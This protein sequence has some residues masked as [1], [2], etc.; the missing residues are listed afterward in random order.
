MLCAVLGLC[1]CA[2]SWSNPQAAPEWT[3]GFWF[4]GGKP[5]SASLSDEPDVLFVHVGTISKEESRWSL[6]SSQNPWHVVGQWPDDLPAAKEYWLVYRYEKQAV[7][8]AVVA[9]LLADEVAR[10]L[11][12]ARTRRLAVRGVQLDIDSPSSRLLEYAAFL[13]G[14]R[15][16]LPKDCQLSITALLDWF[17]NGTAIEKVIQV[18]D[19]FV[20]QFYD[21]E[22]EQFRQQ[23]S[24]ATLVDADRWGP[25]FNRFGKR[26]RIGISSFGRARIVHNEVPAAA[27]YLGLGMFGDLAP[28]DVATNPDFRLETKRTRAEEVVLTY[29][30]AR[31]IEIDYAKFNAGEGV[32]FTLATPE[33]VRDAVDRARQMKGNLAGV[34][35]FRWPNEEEKLAM[36]P[37]E[38]LVA[39]GLSSTKDPQTDRIDLIDGRCAAVQCMDVYFSAAAPFAETTTRYR[40]RASGELEYF[41][42]EK[43]LPVRMRGQ[44]E[45]ELA[46]PPY[47][48]RGHL[49]L[50]RAVSARRV[51]FSVEEAR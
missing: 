37:Q 48:G 18:A 28:I 14:F 20:P 29:R 46:V 24:I 11:R 51:K 6:R 26:F 31:K 7:P 44:S 4:W 22:P 49:Y 32:Q 1:S 3:T 30:A 34:V 10:L 41:L 25:V 42:P 40:I 23:G 27:R 16:A 21:A 15:K 9:P 12:V 39:G 8:E 45:L 38:V 33:S 35:F 5:A 36:R 13:R 19:E 17:R 2:V 50:G 47:C 43:S